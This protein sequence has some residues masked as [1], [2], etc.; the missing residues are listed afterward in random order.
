VPEDFV[1]QP[2]HFRIGFGAATETVRGRL[3]HLDAA[4]KAFPQK[5][6]E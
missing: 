5:A 4:L 3:E 6:R 1:E 2:P